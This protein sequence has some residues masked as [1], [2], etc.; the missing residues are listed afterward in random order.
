MD[1][2]LV[3]DG[4]LAGWFWMDGWLVGWL[5]LNLVGAPCLLTYPLNC[6]TDDVCAGKADLILSA[7]AHLKDSKLALTWAKGTFL[8]CRW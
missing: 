4:W 5:V 6:T 1:G 2:W 3:L 7:R 8:L